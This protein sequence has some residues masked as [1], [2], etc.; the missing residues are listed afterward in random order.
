MGVAEVMLG[1]E[2]EEAAAVEDLREVAALVQ[3]GA[4]EVGE[5]IVVG[6]AEEV[7]GAFGTDAEDSVTSGK[8]L[9]SSESSAAAARGDGGGEMSRWLVEIEEAIT[10]GGAVHVKEW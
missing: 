10:A 5:A 6:V 8:A 9:S 1:A 2:E 4:E 7:F 3:R